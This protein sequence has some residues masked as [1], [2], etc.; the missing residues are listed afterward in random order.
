VKRYALIMLVAFIASARA[1][2]P[3]TVTF[4]A[5]LVDEKS[6]AALTGSH[7]IAFSL[8]DADVDGRSVWT[9]THDVSP[10][11]GLVYVEL[12]STSPLD[13]TVFTGRK[14][15][16]QVSLDGTIMDPRIALDSVPYSIRASSAGNA[17]AVGGIPASGLQPKITGTCASGQHV[18]TINPDGTV[19]CA[20]DTGGAGAINGVIA[21]NGLAGGGTS[22][23][24]TVSLAP[25]GPNEI[26]KWNG[27]MWGCAMDANSGGDITGISIGAAGGLVGGGASGDVTLSLPTV[28]A[29]GQ[30]LKWNGVSWGCANDIDTDTNS[31]GTITSVSVGSPGGLMGGGTTGAISLSLPNNCAGGQL[32]KWSGSVWQC[33]NDTDTDTNSGGTITS[34]TAGAGLTGGST[35]GNAT[36]NVGQGVGVVVQAD[37]VGLDTAYTDMRYLMLSGGLMQGAIDMGGHTLTNRSCPG[38]YTSVGPTLCV[39]TT[40]ECCYTFS[41]AA[42]HCRLQGAHLCS[43]AEM[44]AVMKSGVTITNG[45]I[46]DWMDDQDSDDNAMY[47]NNASADN[48]DGSR[49]TTT[50]SWTRCCLDL[51]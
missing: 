39:Q 20:A 1:D 46:S 13:G 23:T 25:C 6:N 40:D 24:V 43:S 26:F 15:W 49:V 37:T 42:D 10:Q 5:R 18:S 28:C 32:L 36:V 19:G 51:E 48:P 41:N 31:G 4:T 50:S 16:L 27:A 12:G 14:L 22:G 8:F 33:A 34:V 9:E 45:P 35:T 44:R 30:L 47:V 2:V 17:D 21:G 29:M 3:T 38:A 7:S 11:E